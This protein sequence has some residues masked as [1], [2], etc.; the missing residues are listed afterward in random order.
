VILAVFGSLAMDG[1]TDGGERVPP[2]NFGCNG[3][4]WVMQGDRG[5]ARLGVLQPSFKLFDAQLQCRDIA[6]ERR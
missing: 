5:L 1:G 3:S 4:I 2:V 6:C